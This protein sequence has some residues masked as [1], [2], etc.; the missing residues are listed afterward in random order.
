MKKLIITF[1]ITFTVN[2]MRAQEKPEIRQGQ[3][4]EYTVQA[5]GGIFPM[6]FDIDSLSD[7]RFELSWRLSQS[8]GRFIMNKLSLDS[9]PDCYW[10]Q[11]RDFEEFILPSSQNLLMVSRKIFKTLKEDKQAVF[12]GA[13]LSLKENKADPFI[14]NGKTIDAVYA[15]SESGLRIWILN[16]PITPLFLKIE[17]NPYMVDATLDRINNNIN[18]KTKQ[19]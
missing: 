16:D 5:G 6:T 17:N 8:K 19:P 2:H 14:L 13:L 11:P 15:E 1:A 4:L 7:S 12:D 10:E 3:T 9:A 18:F